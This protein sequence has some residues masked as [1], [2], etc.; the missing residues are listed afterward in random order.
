MTNSPAGRTR[1]SGRK[2]VDAE[3][4]RRFEQACDSHGQVPP[5]HNGRY[6]W[7]QRRLKEDFDE[8]ISIET[9]RKYFSGEARPRP[10]KM[11]KLAQLL[12][13]DE[14]WLSLGIDQNLTPRERRLRNAMVDGAVNLVA[15]LI[16]MD[17]G[18]VAF[19][20][21][22]DVDAAESG[23]DL[24]TIIRGGKF[25]I[26]VTLGEVNEDGT[27]RFS[28]PAKFTAV[29]VLGLVRDGF[30]FRIFNI[31]NE[32]IEAGRKRGLTV[33]VNVSLDQLNEIDSFRNR[34]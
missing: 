28:A 19:P 4:A 14:S 2:I 22:D 7:V 24:H 12:Q 30:N 18:V 1:A 17:G 32:V 33:D 23:V 26:H 3:F 13:V 27:W 8:D 25:D 21:D 20:A 16:Q 31:E 29:V 11:A 9:I 15:G 6:A 34:L 5:L 10:T